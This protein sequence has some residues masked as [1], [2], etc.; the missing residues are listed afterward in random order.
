M[1]KKNIKRTKEIIESG[2]FGKYDLIVETEDCLHT[3]QPKE[4]A[5]SWDW[6]R[7]ITRTIVACFDNPEKSGKN[8]ADKYELCWKR[9]E[10]VTEQDIANARKQIE[11]IENG[12]TMQLTEWEN[13]HWVTNVSHKQNYGFSA[14]DLRKLVK[15]YKKASPHRQF[16]YEELLTDCNFHTF[17]GKLAKKDYDACELWILRTYE[18]ETF[19][20]TFR[21]P[22]NIGIDKL[23]MLK[24]KISQAV[25]NLGIGTMHEAFHD[26]EG[27]IIIPK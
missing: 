6:H 19:P 22:N 11:A 9:N 16:G 10:K 4:L 8:K 7:V 27:Y 2:L 17:C 3:Q 13:K 26:E 21:I 23:N 25:E 18:K 1:A 20:V 14:P 24:E 5:C 12:N 15:A